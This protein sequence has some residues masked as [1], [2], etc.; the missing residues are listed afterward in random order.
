MNKDVDKI[1]FYKKPIRHPQQTQNGAHNIF[2]HKHTSKWQAVLRIR[3]YFFRI[4]D[5]RI[6]SW[7]TDPDKEG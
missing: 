2:L 5:Q 4:Q 1:C 7:I 3:K 6:Q